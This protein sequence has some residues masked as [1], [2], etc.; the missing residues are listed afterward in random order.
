MLTL[1]RAR[2]PVAPLPAA[3]VSSP[4]DPL[5]P[6]ALCGL[7]HRGRAAPALAWQ[8]AKAFATVGLTL[9]LLQWYVAFISVSG[10]WFLLWQSRT[11]NGRDAAFRMFAM[12]GLS[13]RD[14]DLAA[15]G[16]AA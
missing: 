13:L 15:A 6:S 9:S 16:P 3:L 5:E 2:M 1:R 7:A 4:A 10:E 11:W 14:D 8:K 12:M